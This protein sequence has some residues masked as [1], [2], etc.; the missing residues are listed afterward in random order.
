MNRTPYQGVANIVRFNPGMFIAAG[1]ATLAGVI[2]LKLTA[3]WFQLFIAVLLAFAILSLI[4]SLVVSHWIYDRSEIYSLPSLGNYQSTENENW[5]TIN[6]GFDEISLTLKEQ[7]PDINLRI[8]DFYDPAKHTEPSIARARN[9]YPPHP[10]T[11]TISSSSIPADDS[12]IE[13]IIAFFSLHE[14]RDNQERFCTFKELH[15]ALTDDGEMHLTEHVRDI[16]NLL[17][18][19]LGA[20]HFHTRSTWLK[21]FEESNFAI[22]SEIKTTPFV[23]TFVLIKK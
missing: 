3:G 8:L 12:S 10:N 23:T 21:T 15:R 2:A 22:K 17:A 20:F 16:P 9:A 1:F 14:I 11:E 13:K 6:A 4:I 7:Y 18:Y 19:H 5:L